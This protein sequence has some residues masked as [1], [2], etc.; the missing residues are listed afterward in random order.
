MF[1]S[2]YLLLG[3]I[4]VLIAFI[5]I[6]FFDRQAVFRKVKFLFHIQLSLRILGMMSMSRCLGPVVTCFLLKMRYIFQVIFEVLNT[7]VATD[8]NYN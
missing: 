1:D 3:Q 6:Y 7:T 8:F 5:F 2:H 4:I